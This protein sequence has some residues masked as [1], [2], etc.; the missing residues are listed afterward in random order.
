MKLLIATATAVLVA[1]QAFAGSYEVRC[2]TTKVPYQETVK[3]G[4]P[5]KVIGGAIIGGVLGKVVTKENAGAAAGAIIGGAVANET[6]KRTVTKYKDVETCTNVFIPERVT[7][8]ERLRQALL[9]LN[10]GK[11]VSKEMI[12]DVQYTIGVGHDGKWGPKSKL[13][14]EKYLANLEPDAPLYS[15]VVN[16]VVIVS[17][18]DV[19]AVDQIKDALLEAGVDSQIFVDLQQ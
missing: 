2:E 18:A 10:G 15:L 12:M 3:G 7:D 11:S 9:D 6:S 19:N 8:E 1:S 4:T 16:D 13:A 14:A 17:S 5:E